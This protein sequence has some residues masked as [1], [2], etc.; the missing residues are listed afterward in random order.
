LHQEMENNR[1]KP[2][3]YADGTLPAALSFAGRVS[4]QRPLIRAVYSCD[5]VTRHRRAPARTPPMGRLR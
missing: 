4:E 2:M 5:Q 1:M 3:G